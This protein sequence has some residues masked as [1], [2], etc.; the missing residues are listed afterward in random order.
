MLFRSDEY[1]ERYKHDKQK[2]QENNPEA[3]RRRMDILDKEEL[4][5]LEK[6]IADLEKQTK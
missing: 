5:K 2:G 1:E 6:K 4:K 3:H